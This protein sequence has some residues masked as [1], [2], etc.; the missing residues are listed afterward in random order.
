MPHA[1]TGGRP[2]PLCH[3]RLLC[4]DRARPGHPQL[5]RGRGKPNRRSTR[6]SPP[7]WKRPAG[8]SRTSHP[9]CPEAIALSGFIVA[10]SGAC[11]R[12]KHCRGRR[13]ASARMCGTG[14]SNAPWLR[15]DFR[16]D[17]FSADP[18][19]SC[20]WQQTNHVKGAEFRTYKDRSEEVP[21]ICPLV[22]RPVR[23]RRC[24]IIVANRSPQ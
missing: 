19:S 9:V 11:G 12:R 5:C 2:L 23:Q 15:Y 14:T 7:K 1:S 18:A 3:D 10:R 17:E 16:L 13:S 6:A 21:A 24:A 22:Y 20:R 4:H 8:W